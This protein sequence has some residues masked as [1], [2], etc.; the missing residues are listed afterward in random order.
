MVGWGID[1][2]SKTRYNVNMMKRELKLTVFAL[3]L[4]AFI[5]VSLELLFNYLRTGTVTLSPTIQGMDDDWGLFMI[6]IISVAVILFFII[7]QTSWK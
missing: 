6:L 4:A 5:T 1:K 3:L 2:E 7:K